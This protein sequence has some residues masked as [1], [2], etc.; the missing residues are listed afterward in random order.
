MGRGNVEYEEGTRSPKDFLYG[1]VIVKFLHTK[2]KFHLIGKRR[3]LSNWLA[4]ALSL[5]QIAYQYPSP[6]RLVARGI[7]CPEPIRSE[8]QL[9]QCTAR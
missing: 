7:R 5:N 9:D 2:Q 3:D 8:V 4:E 6:P 1:R